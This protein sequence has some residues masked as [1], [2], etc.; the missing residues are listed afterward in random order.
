[1][2]TVANIQFDL[3]GFALTDDSKEFTFW[4]LE[5]A[6]AIC[7]KYSILVFDLGGFALT[8]DSRVSVLGAPVRKCE[9]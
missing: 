5:F 8:D 3:R 1:L 7:S 4:V 6:L 2:R 9:L